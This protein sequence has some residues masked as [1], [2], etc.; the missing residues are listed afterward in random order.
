MGTGCGEG[1]SHSP[2]GVGLGRV[3]NL[4]FKGRVLVDS[5]V[6][7]VPAVTRTRA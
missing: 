5:D 6:L 1:V 3:F 2:L 4:L 7:N